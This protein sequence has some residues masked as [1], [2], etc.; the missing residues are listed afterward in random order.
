MNK[1]RKNKNKKNKNK[2]R[3]NK[4]NKIFFSAVFLI[5]LDQTTKILVKTN[6][7]IG[8][9]IRVFDWFYIYFIE[10]KK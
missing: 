3:I 1:Q 10:N 8:E 2:G 7:I 6:M 5:L 4:L 9:S